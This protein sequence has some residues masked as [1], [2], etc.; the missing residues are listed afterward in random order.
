ME[1]KLTLILIVLAFAFLAQAEITSR[2]LRN[3]ESIQRLLL[4]L[5]PSDI[6]IQKSTTEREIFG[7]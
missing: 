4:L 5:I 7:A 1:G 3:I 2:R 6:L